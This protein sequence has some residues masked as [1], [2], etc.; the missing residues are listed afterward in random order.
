MKRIYLIVIALLLVG[1][2]NAQAQF[3][4]GVKGGLNLPS[5]KDAGGTID[6]NNKTG[7]HGGVMAELKV[8]LFGVQ[9]DLIYSQNAFEVPSVGDLKTSYI[10][11]PIVAKLYMLK[12]LNIQLGP[13][14]TYMTSSKLAD[15][16]ILDDFK[17]SNFR[18]VAGLGAKLGP[19]DIH[20]RFIFPSK[21]ET[22][23]IPGELKNSNIQISIGYWLKN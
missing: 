14:F 21:T 1:A 3:K 5:L 10:D 22:L 6:I 19:M 23:Q 13:Q 18:F 16:D 17:E 9:A 12:V 2:F 8:P 11:V 20:G 4:F 15:V 7:W